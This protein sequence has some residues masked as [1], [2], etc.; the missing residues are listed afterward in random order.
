[1]NL[2][3]RPFSAYLSPRCPG[4]TRAQVIFA[5]E[6]AL[7]FGLTAYATLNLTRT[8]ASVC[9]LWP[10][11]GIFLAALLITPSFRLRRLIVGLCI[12]AIAAANLAWGMSLVAT[13]GYAFANVAEVL[14]A[15]LMLQKV[16]LSTLSF[17]NVRDFLRFVLVCGVIGPMVSSL[18]GA[19]VTVWAFDAPFLKAFQTWFISDS[20]GLL[21]ITPVFVML[22]QGT[23]DEAYAPPRR[24]IAYHFAFLTI[25][26]VAIFSQT[27]A[28]LLFLVTPAMVLIAF[29]LGPRYT[30]IATVILSIIAIGFTFQGLGPAS[31]VASSDPSLKIGLIQL[32]CF[33]NFVMAVTVAAQVAEQRLLRKSLRE[34]STI[35][36]RNGRQLRAALSNLSQGVCLL[37]ADR[38]IVVRNDK[39]L[40]IYGLAHDQVPTGQTFGDLL[41]V[42]VA[43]GCEPDTD[44]H[45][46]HL[47]CDGEFEQQLKDGRHIK[48]CQSK[49]EDGGMICTYTDVTA[50][51]KAEEALVHR[52]LHDVLTGLPNRRLLIDRLDQVVAQVGR[53]AAGAVMLLD[54]DHFKGINDSLGHAAGDDLLK[55]VSQRL[56]ECIRDGDTVGRLGGDE[57]AIVLPDASGVAAPEVVAARVLQAMSKPM[58][59]DGNEATIGMSVGVAVIARTMT[60][61]DALKAADTA[62]YRAKAEGRNTFAFH[63]GMFCDSNGAGIELHLGSRPEEGNKEKLPGGPKP[64][65]RAVGDRSAKTSRKATARA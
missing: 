42:C 7:A 62:L 22:H 1:M 38:R 60:R 56:L 50:D 64:V 45:V 13:L 27:V 6:V 51:R 29:R 5:V 32:Y 63:D 3:S 35:A 16:N 34:M 37:D 2:G 30:A 36:D 18:V 15:L 54:V 48:V 46:V 19:G 17:T 61:D 4:L 8:T 39:F 23:T 9:A 53:G 20:L 11:N 49:L 59:L 65:S 52:T 44:A 47:D 57:F 41:A 55:I 40:A 21:I 12:V 28:P 58:V 25:L 14:T 10:A 43:A 26:A 24:E 33:T 31:L